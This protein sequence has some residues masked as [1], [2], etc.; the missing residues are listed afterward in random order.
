MP[1]RLSL[2]PL[3]LVVAGLGSTLAAQ[4]PATDTTL[5]TVDRIFASPEFRLG[6]LSALAWLSDGAGYTTLERAAGGGGDG[7]G[8]G[9]TGQDLVRY[10]AETG[11]KTILVPASR[12]VPPGDSTPLEV[13]EYS[14][15]PDGRRLLIF[16]NSKQVWRTNTRGDYWVLDLAGWTL[17]KLGGNGPGS[18]LMF[19]KFSPD[20]GRV[21]WVRYG[22]YNIYV[23]DIASGKMT[24]LTHDG[25]R[26]TINGTFDWVYEEEFG[27]QDGWRWNPDGQSIA[28]WQLDATG[29][30][31]FLL[32]DVTDSLYAF[33][34]PVQYPKAGQSN[35]A[36][37]AGVVSVSGGETRW[38]NMPG[39]PRNNYIARMEWVP[40]KGRS[41]EL[42]IQHMNR[43]QDTLH[44]MLADAQS[45]QAR[46]L[47]TEADVPWVEHFDQLRFLN[48]GKDILWMSERSGWSQ[49]YLVP[50]DGGA[51][52]PLTSGEF[53]VFGVVRVD[54]IGKW[55]YYVASP[56]N[57]MQR[58]LYRINYAKRGPA[59]R[60]T[61]QGEPGW[62]NYSLSPTGRYAVHTY[63]RFGVPPTISL[64]SLPDNHMLRTLV[65][66]A[67]LKAKLATLRL[68]ATE[69][70]QVDIGN[71][72]KLNAAFIKPPN[73]DS[74]GGARYP[75]FFY[76]YGGPGSQTVTDNWGGQNYLWYQMLAQR[77]YIV[78]SVDNRGTG[79]R[80]KAWRKIIYKQLGVIETQDQA[81]AA[82]AIGRL[83]FVDSTRIG[84]WGWSY[85]GFMTLNVLTQA[86]DVY[87]M[88]IAVAPVTHWKYYDTIYTERYNGLPQDNAAGYDKGSP[89]TYAKNLKGRLLIVHGSGDDNVHFQNTEAMVN[90]LIEANR[91]FS[92]M[93][94]PNRNHGIYGGNTRQHLYTLLTKFVEENLP[95]ATT[96]GTRAALP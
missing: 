27:L 9:K 91:P 39:D 41:K 67:P 64:V 43:L 2:Y 34:I 77:G 18:T 58:Y 65:D 92:L 56:D 62:H 52:R 21:G 89:L 57:P 53:D 69:F 75:V 44:V 82:R 50:R 93:V 36:G 16:T 13:E 46:T 74:T 76:V 80:G 48:D 49:L 24:Q 71:G 14:W 15:S 86:P 96:G 5:L 31:D 72:I 61:P 6:S 10:D 20:G 79:A 90:A 23:E 30:R 11:L 63:S 25:S 68:G 29:V 26:T 19:A 7:G 32:D 8:G 94:Y 88:G 3:A 38:L 95:A 85:G 54:T 78:A 47:F 45:G 70:R 55:I 73:F 60:I 12:L 51:P 28:Y 84:I 42:V 81:A 83:P 59:Q 17:K 35:S 40:A 1:R 66:N 4:R 87:R 22:E 33:T 37:R